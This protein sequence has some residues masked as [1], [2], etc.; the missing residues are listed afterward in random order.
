[1]SS[2]DTAAHGG[3]Q[4]ER[5]RRTTPPGERCHAARPLPEQRAVRWIVRG[6]SAKIVGKAEADRCLLSATR[7]PARSNPSTP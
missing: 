5:P 1:L 4:V 7:S 3:G 2:S 6:S